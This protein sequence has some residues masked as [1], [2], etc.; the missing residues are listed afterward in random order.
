MQTW[1]AETD[2]ADLLSPLRAT[3]T[4]SEDVWNSIE[5]PKVKD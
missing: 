2:E 1:L 3:A 4:S 5:G